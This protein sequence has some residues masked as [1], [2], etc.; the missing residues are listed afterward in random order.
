MGLLSDITAYIDS[1][2][3]T[4]GNTLRETVSDPVGLLQMRLN[5]VAEQLPAYPGK[6]SVMPGG[7]GGGLL[8]RPN[9]VDWGQAVAMNA[10]Q[11][12]GLLGVTKYAKTADKVERALNKMGVETQRDA[13]RVSSSQYIEATM[14]NGDLVKIRVSD[15]ELPHYYGTATRAD[16]NVAIGPHGRADT[17]GDWADVIKLIGD[18]YQL[19][20]PQYANRVLT[21]R[22]ALAE[23]IQSN[24]TKAQTAADLAKQGQLDAALSWVLKQPPNVTV[25][26]SRRG[27]MISRIG[28]QVVG[29]I[30]GF[31]REWATGTQAAKGNAPSM[32]KDDAV[33]FL[34]KAGA[35]P[36]TASR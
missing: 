30:D 2:K 16:Y 21:N 24:A 25:G 33:A 9:I 36:E 1:L 5:Q 3:R 35:R 34:L 13:S 27:N 8:S 29:T 23:S 14:P 26:V 22:K 11:P 32:I 10:N 28:D 15:H 6:E 31:P 12:M 18:K 4:A 7:E 19:P 17:S 20:I